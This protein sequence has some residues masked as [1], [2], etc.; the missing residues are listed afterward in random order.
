MALFKIYSSSAGSGK[1]FVLAKE[2]LKL[3]LSSDQPLYFKCVLALT[4]TIAS[5]DEMKNRILDNLKDMGENK[6][7]PYLVLIQKETAM[8]LDVLQKRA[9]TI[10]FQ[11]LNNY[12]DFAIMTLDSFASKIVNTFRYDLNIPLQ[13]EVILDSKPIISDAINRILQ[14]LSD[15]DFKYLRK[16]VLNFMKMEFE[17]DKNWLKVADNL[18]EYF[19]HAYL[20]PIKDQIFG[21]NVSLDIYIDIEI[22]IRQYLQTTFSYLKEEAERAMRLIDSVGISY[23][24]F[25]QG[26][27][28]LGSFLYR[29][30]GLKVK[31][32]YKENLA[33]MD[34]NSYVRNT[35]ENDVW[36]S[37][38]G[39]HLETK[40]DKIKEE[41]RVILITLVEAYK[42]EKLIWRSQFLN[43]NY[44][45]L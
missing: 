13:S 22:K 1:T 19:K 11:I 6:Q 36:F 29:N 5:T 42:I 15:E 31:S 21:N 41:I 38:K 16:S 39:K 32:G 2:Y 33:L 45:L 9:K 37:E 4:F 40:F 34:A 25:T 10:F 8:D 28:G 18:E 20:N 35:L 14:K 24:D 30:T 44:L 3:V 7:N 26:S 17:E 27:K 43:F 23:L 12:S